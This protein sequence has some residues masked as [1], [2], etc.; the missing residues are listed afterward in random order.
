[1]VENSQ[2]IL[3]QIKI[4]NHSDGEGGGAKSNKDLVHVNIS[5]YDEDGNLFYANNIL[6]PMKIIA[7]EEKQGPG[8]GY[9]RGLIYG[10][11]GIKKNQKRTIIFPPEL[12]YNIPKEKRG[13]NGVPER[14]PGGL[15]LDS[16]IVM[17]LECKYIENI[18]GK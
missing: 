4:I 11:V 14:G 12:G 18:N 15:D 2:Q 1:M 8:P 6:H 17:E 9:I 13:I 7:G 16:Y 10:V 3:D 5:G